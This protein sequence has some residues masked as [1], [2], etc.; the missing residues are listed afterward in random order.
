ML[1]KNDT[2]YY[3]IAIPD[4]KQNTS[5]LIFNNIKASIKFN[6]KTFNFLFKFSNQTKRAI[7]TTIIY[8]SRSKIQCN[9]VKRNQVYIFERPKV[10]NSHYLEII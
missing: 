7:T 9:Q 4:T 8:C 3:T 2:K 1:K 10:H 5:I 6:G